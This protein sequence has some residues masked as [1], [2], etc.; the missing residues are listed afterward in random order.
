MLAKPSIE[1]RLSPANKANFKPC[2]PG[3]EHVNRYWDNSH[4]SVSAKILP[5]EYYVTR[6]DEL[7]TTVLGSCISV[8][9]YDPIAGVGGMNHFML[10]KSASKDIELLSDSFRYGDV[11]M[12]R[13]INSLLKIGAGKNRLVFKAFGGGQIIRNMTSIGERNIKFLHQFMTME[14]FVLDASDLGGPNPRKVV[15]SPQTGKVM[16][17][18]LEHMHND[19]IVAREDKYQTQLSTE[20]STSGD[21]DLFD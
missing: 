14:G 9:I 4:K 20:E 8:C 5:G 6:N 7:I 3:F 16:L 15:F 13:L 10:P 1:S 17:K 21:I 18:R 2:E 19:T 11:A 12:E